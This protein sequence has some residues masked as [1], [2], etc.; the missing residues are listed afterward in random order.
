MMSMLSRQIHSLRLLII[1]P[2]ILANVSNEMHNDMRDKKR[3]K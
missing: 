2:P 1:D 3:L